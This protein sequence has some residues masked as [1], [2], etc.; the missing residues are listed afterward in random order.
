MKPPALVTWDAGGQL[1]MP[2]RRMQAKG[3]LYQDGN[4][5]RLRWW[6]D[7]RK[8]D[9]SLHRARRSAIIG[10]A[11]GPGKLSKKQAQAKAQ[12]DILTTVNAKAFVP[13][14][15]MTLEQFITQRF[16]PDVVWTK[17]H[18]GKLHYQYCFSKIIPALGQVKLRDLDVETVQT[19]IHGIL[20]SGKS[21]QTA[22]HMKNALSAIIS[23]AKRLRF[24]TGE[25]PASLVLLPA[26]QPKKNPALW[27]EQ[28]QSLL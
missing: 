23:H 5:W 16:E 21:P 18:A 7:E 22:T 27:W 14:S 20:R 15:M 9:G 11:T 24:Y 6:E 13:Q 2:R 25:N 26:V 3:N 12:E 19:F 28:A 1:D 17:K 4:W 8:P 10:P